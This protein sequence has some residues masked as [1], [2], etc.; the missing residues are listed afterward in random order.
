MDI[1]KYVKISFF[2]SIILVILLY[3]SGQIF[4]PREREVIEFQCEEFVSEWERVLDNG[5]RV[6]VEVPGKTEAEWGKEIKYC[7]IL[8]ENLEDNK[9]LAFRT[10][11]QD[12]K[13]YID[14]ELRTEYSTKDSRFFGRNS[15][16]RYVF[17]ELEP[18]DAG[19]ELTY[20]LT[21][22]SKYSG[23]IRNVF[24][25]DKMGVMLHLF[26]E[27]G[28]KS[29]LAAFLLMLG[30]FCITICLFSKFVYKKHLTISYLV[31]A[32]MLCSVWMLSEMEFRQLLFHN[33]STLAYMTYISI[34]LIPVPFVLYINEIQ[35]DRYKKIFAIPL[36]YAMVVFIMAVVLQIFN[37]V[38]FLQI[39]PFAHI[40]IAFSSVCIIVTVLNDIRNG[41][42]KEYIYVGIGILGLVVATFIEIILYYM[43]ITVTI[44]AALVIGLM[45]LLVMAII[46]TGQ[47]LMESENLKK[48]AIMAREAQT[49]FLANMSHEIRTPINAVIGMNEMILRESKNEDVLGYAE[50]IKSASN[51]LLGLVSDILDFSKI[52]SGKI[53]IVNS[54]YETANLIR[55]EKLILNVRASQKKL[56][57]HTEIDETLPS[58]LSG[59]ELHIKQIV[60]NL[61]SNAVKYTEEGS[62]TLKVYHKNADENN[63]DLYFSV[64]D[65]G[66][67]I[68]PENMKVLFESFKRLEIE[69]NRNIQGTGLGLSIAKQLTELMNGELAVESEYGKGSKFTM[70]VR[71]QIIDKSP[72]D[73]KNVF[74][75][76]SHI[77]KNTK[78]R[79]FIA[80][81]AKVLVVDDNEMNLSVIKM[82]LKRT[83]IQADTATGG[84]DAVEKTKQ[85][86]YDLILLD[87][88]MPELDGIETLKI[89]RNDESNLNSKSIII[90]LTANAVAGCKEEYLRQGFDDYFSKPI[91]ADKFDDL[92]LKYLPGELIEWND[93]EKPKNVLDSTVGL[94]YCMNDN[95][96]Y[97]EMLE[98]FYN[99]SEKY[100]D[101]LTVAYENMDWYNYSLISHTVKSNAK[102]IGAVYLSE[103]SYKHEEA[104]KNEDIDFIYCE[105]ENYKKMI[106]E[107]NVIAMDMFKK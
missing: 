3:L 16:F 92:L 35:K 39:L 56:S 41:K 50:N 20:C 100:M 57:I 86:K 83:L 102:T 37:V 93:D 81:E 64:E 68:K 105:F 90:V 15:S 58:K 44:G 21:T 45:F 52:E 51:M 60:T 74:T 36:T 78:E 47:D 34:M 5:E 107:I 54:E 82:L 46:K 29:V 96:V 103:V 66:I 33:V 1:I 70:R 53:E 77:N 65:T 84:K 22:D 6:D 104:G 4:L 91:Q 27:S 87:H 49:R 14:G 69:K 17:V 101:K 76:N 98:M 99:Q 31:M 19:K 85:N 40:G 43:N 23:T 67:G 18:E 25:G 42:I 9:V 7:T 12:A 97:K 106:S 79:Y 2:V 26:K 24:I 13:I 94:N 88:M 8:P 30:L 59:D 80:K 28:A 61:I 32:T 55:D 48:E 72:I 11:W 95:T 62:V 71:Q 73:L 63:I 38:E 10:V 89:I 75:E